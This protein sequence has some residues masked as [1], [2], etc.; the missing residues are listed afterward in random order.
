LGWRTS[1]ECGPGRKGGDELVGL[2]AR[3]NNPPPPPPPSAQ[4]AMTIEARKRE[5][6][7]ERAVLRAA[8]KLAEEERHKLACDLTD[9]Q[10]R[11]AL[12]KTKY[13]ALCARMRGS[14]DGG[15]G[16]PRS[17]AY[18]ILKAAQKREELQREG[19]ELDSSIR[20]AEREVKAL[21]ATLGHL[22]QRNTAL[23]EALHRVDPGSDEAASVRGLE[24]QAKEAA[25]LVFRRKRELGAVAARLEEGSGQLR[26]VEDRVAMLTSQ[27]AALESSHGK[28]EADRAAQV[29][30]VQTVRDRVEEVRAR[31][32][33]R[34]GTGGAPTP[35]EV[36]FVT[37]GIKESNTSVLFTLGQLAREFPQL[38]PT[39]RAGLERSGLKLPTKPPARPAAAASSA[40]ASSAAAPAAAAAMPSG[41]ASARASGIASG[42]PVRP[43]VGVAPS[44]L[45]AAAGRHIAAGAGLIATPIVTTGGPRGSTPRVPVSPMATG[46]SGGAVGSRPPSAMSRSS[47][48]LE[49]SGSGG[50][51]A[52]SARRGS[53]QG[54]IVRGTSA[55]RTTPS[56]PAAGSVDL[57]VSGAGFAGSVGAAPVGAGTRPPSARSG[58][59]LTPGRASTPGSGR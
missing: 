24:A 18:F 33:A 7:G 36:H 13:E 26:S 19:D 4:L 52:T 22:N 55:G 30:A 29:A 2:R 45:A 39:L 8:A 32:R 6:E 14:E 9:R 57:G 5:V 40:A 49:V 50:V 38:Q 44:P 51:A 53:G 25:D 23:R 47:L 35:D 21:T 31:H 42:G 41:S 58:G 59:R 15:S 11:I 54:T 3:L 17:Q 56:R 37:L 27:V 43:T 16:E 10:A 34:A 46:G 1:R 20:K 48:D 12:L 28:V